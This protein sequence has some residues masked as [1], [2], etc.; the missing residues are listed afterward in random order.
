MDT[1]QNNV[2]DISDGEEAFKALSSLW[3]AGSKQDTVYAGLELQGLPLI[4]VQA[5]MLYIPICLNQ[6]NSGDFQRLHE[7]LKHCAIMPVS[8]IRINHKQ[9]SLNLPE[10]CTEV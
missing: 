4:R 1:I 5:M 10:R 2:S 9:S 6:F 8:N 3:I 7:H